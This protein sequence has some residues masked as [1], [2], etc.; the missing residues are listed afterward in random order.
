M[1]KQCL[2]CRGIA[3]YMKL[4]GLNSPCEECGGK[5]WVEMKDAEPVATP[6]E[7]P[8]EIAPKPEEPTEIAPI[9]VPPKR[10]RP[11]KVPVD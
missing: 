4:G 10:G 6:P 7:Q 11:R 1:R 5:G 8:P 9:P 3:R 2:K